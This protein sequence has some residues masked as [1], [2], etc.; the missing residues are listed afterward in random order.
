MKRSYDFA[1][2]PTKELRY[3]KEVTP[4]HNVIKLSKPTGRT[5]Y[6]AKAAVQIFSKV[7]GNLRK[8]TIV[9]IKE[10]GDNGQ[11][12]EDIVPMDKEDAIIPIRK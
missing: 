9:A 10:F 7:F 5:D 2:Y 12:G 6:D 8:N 3:N 4:R 11:I 1:W